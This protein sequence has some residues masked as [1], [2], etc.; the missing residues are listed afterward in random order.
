M[1]DWLELRQ[2]ADTGIETIRALRR[3]SAH[4]K[5]I[6]VSGGGYAGAI[7]VLTMARYIGASEVLSKPFARQTL[8]A[9]LE[10]LG[11]MSR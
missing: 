9:A 8:L 10:R 5:I 11:L 1:A 3:D 2:H 7:D 6:A 4:V